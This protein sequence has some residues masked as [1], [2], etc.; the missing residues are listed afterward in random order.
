MKHKNLKF[1]RKLPRVTITEQMLQHLRTMYPDNTASSLAKSSRLPYALVYNILHRRVRSLSARH[2]RML[3]NAPPPR[4]T[5]GKVDGTYFRKLVALWLYLDDSATKTSLAEELRGSAQ[6]QTVDYRVFN[7]HIRTVAV[8]LEKAM[9]RKFLQCGI[10]LATI[11]R[12]LIELEQLDA[13]DRVA[14]R[15]LR[16]SLLFLK[17]SVGIHPTALLN[18]LVDR[19][20]GGELKTVSRKVYVRAMA[21]R[22]RAEKALAAGDPQAIER[23]R[24]TVYGRK[25]GYV[26]YATV[27]GELK[28]LQRYGH[29]SPKRYLGRGMHVYEK[30]LCKHIAS[31]R[32]DA[33]IRDCD[34]LI[35]SEHHLPLASLPESH[36]SRLIRPLQGMLL[37]RAAD[38]LAQGD[39]MVLE[40][41]ILTPA[42]SRTEYAR[43][44][45]GFTQF[46]RAP[47]TLGMKKRAFDLMVAKHCDIFK[48]VGRYTSRWYVSDL[49]LK[50]L[51]QN[52][53]FTIVTAKY[54]RMA[55]RLDG[56]APVNRC[57]W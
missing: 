10:D 34:A 14:Y 39:G 30:G 21:L 32:A 35:G 27:A 37:A 12:W 56:S 44:D 38:M 9:E 41:E 23:I 42:H 43:H 7:G 57:R 47:H 4:Q 55:N 29:A 17:A 8:D 22:R 52:V 3:F 45:D 2:Y 48:I 33:I 46:D 36:R 54:E 5:D 16:P 18:Q 24:E 20:E 49:Y 25:P 6:K 15:Q 50:E 26:T 19:Y 53:H 13:D 51:M 40:K 31:W 28:F 1:K 11:D